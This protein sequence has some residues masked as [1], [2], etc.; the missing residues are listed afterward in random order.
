MDVA[1]AYSARNC[2]QM[3]LTQG[4]RTKP[5]LGSPQEHRAIDHRAQGYDVRDK[6]PQ[7]EAS[8]PRLALAVTDTC[9]HASLFAS[10]LSSTLTRFLD[11]H[12]ATSL[13]LTTNSSMDVDE[14]PRNGARESET[15]IIVEFFADATY[16][17]A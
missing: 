16:L 7:R 3:R 17:G 1:R 15:G 13:P 14:A 2:R 6:T 12:A 4:F 8:R 5:P 11:A 9:S 10:E